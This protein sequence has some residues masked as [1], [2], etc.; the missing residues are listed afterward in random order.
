MKWFTNQRRSSST[1]RDPE[2]LLIKIGPL[3]NDS[4]QNDPK[5]EPEEDEEAANKGKFL[6]ENDPKRDTRCQPKK[7]F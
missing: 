3:K 5:K 7:E 4:T 6:L 1:S 2:P